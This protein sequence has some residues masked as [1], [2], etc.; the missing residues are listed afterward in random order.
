MIWYTTVQY[1][2]VQYS[3]TQYSN[4]LFYLN[5]YI[6]HFKLT[7]SALVQDM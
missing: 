3:S 1:D 5:V 6:L 7:G 4:L 2:T